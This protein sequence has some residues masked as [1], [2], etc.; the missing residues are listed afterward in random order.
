M[1]TTVVVYVNMNSV[2][3]LLFGL[4]KTF[5]EGYYESVNLFQITMSK[6]EELSLETPEQEAKRLQEKLLEVPVDSVDA[7][8]A[9]TGIAEAA[10]LKEE[11]YAQEAEDRAKAD[12]LVAQIKGE[13]PVAEG[14][15]PQQTEQQEDGESYEKAQ[16]ILRRLHA[17]ADYAEGA[18]DIG[19][20]RISPTAKAGVDELKAL[21]PK[22]DQRKLAEDF[23]DMPLS[24]RGQGFLQV[25]LALK[26]TEFSNRFKELESA[27][28]KEGGYGEFTI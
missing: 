1:K 15:A 3:C 10:V 24:Q 6:F 9:S 2:K 7:A 21:L 4:T 28:L 11:A 13:G 27:R 22:I 8:Q 20:G 14:A 12:A 23:F 25:Y 5:G 19:W 17:G 16:E 18:M 26:G